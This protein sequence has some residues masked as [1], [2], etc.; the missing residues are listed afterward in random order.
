MPNGSWGGGGRGLFDGAD[1]VRMR[2]SQSTN[3]V[4]GN[5][6]SVGD[7]SERKNSVRGNPVTEFAAGWRQLGTEV[8]LSFLFYSVG[9]FYLPSFYERDGQVL[10]PSVQLN[11]RAG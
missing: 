10:A 11:E 2:R 6:R 1:R 7:W 5:G 8:T 3:G 4:G 9:K